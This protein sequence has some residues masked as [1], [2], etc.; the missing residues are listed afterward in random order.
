MVGIGVAVTIIAVG[1]GAWLL[2]M[3]FGTTLMSATTTA[4]TAVITAANIC[5]LLNPFGDEGCSDI[6]DLSMLMDI[7]NVI[8]TTARFFGVV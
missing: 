6:N 2:L 5:G 8:Y 3:R 4:V 1:V 7:N